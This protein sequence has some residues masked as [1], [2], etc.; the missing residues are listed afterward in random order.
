MLKNHLT[1]ALRNLW[2]NKFHAFINVVGLSIGISACLAIFLIVRHELSFDTFRQDQDQIYRIHSKF[3]G[4]FEAYNKG[5][6][7]SMAAFVQDQFSA[8]ELV[9]P[10]HVINEQVQV[11]GPEGALP[12]EMDYQRDLVIVSPDF[13]TLFPDF[14]WISGSP[15]TS[16]SAPNQVVLTTDKAIKYFGNDNPNAIVGQQLVYRDSLVLTVSGIIASEKRRTDLKFGDFISFATISNSWLSNQIRLDDWSSTNS[17]SQLLVKVE[18]GADIT[19]LQNKLNTLAGGRYLKENPESSWKL[20]F[21]LQSFEDTHFNTKLGT[22]DGKRTPTHLPTMKALILIAILLLVIAAINYINLETAQ[23]MRRSK[24]VGVRKVLGSSRKGLVLQFLGETLVLTITAVLLSLQLATFG[25]K[26][27]GEFIPEGIQL[28]LNDPLIVGFLIGVTLIVTLLAGFYPA[29]VLSSFRPVVALKDQFSA[30]KQNIKTAHLRRGLIVFQFIFSI[31]LIFG[32]FV[33]SRQVDY[34]VNKDMGF[35]ENEVIYFDT[36]WRAQPEKKKVLEQQL[37]QLPE[38]VDITLS[39]QP[40][41]YGGTSSTV[42]KYDNGKET[43]LH[44]V[45]LKFGD[46]SYLRFYNLELLAGRNIQPTDSIR[47]FII[48][49]TYLHQL[50]FTEPGEAIGQHLIYDKDKIYPIVGVIKDFHIQSLHNAIPPILIANEMTHSGCF[51]LRLS[52][53]EKTAA[54]FQQTLD[55]IQ[56]IWKEIYP[57]ETFKHYFL[58]ETLA[59]FYETEQQTAKLMSAATLVA[60]LISCLGLLGLISFIATQRTKEIGIRKVL[61][62]SVAQIV[63]LLSKEFIK[64]VVLAGFI[65]FPL[66]WWGMNYWLSDFVYHIDIEW[67]MFVVVGL[68][69]LGVAVF[70]L[71]FRAIRAALA[72]P[73]KA[74]RSE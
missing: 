57:K 74:L 48:N 31:S 26:Y 8:F 58:D 13:F 52:T 4:S 7:A 60:I 19:Q 42:I 27:F 34:L 53:G 59:G 44:D 18:K 35:E 55:K 54:G 3:S 12:K 63:L 15:V 16:L 47:E 62:A 11:I 17:N 2:R 28:H 69:V 20:D 49:E 36:P 56:Q 21:I 10:L 43:V 50:G 33:I 46:T 45:Y 65:G 67:W 9:A 25:L 22:I 29:F 5:V 73:V 71:C 24:E 39:H 30:L 14:V 64:L 66:A 37:R 1:L 70:T 23:S 40:P 41:A 6:L 51:N 68:A 32:T 61:G 38:L 72:N